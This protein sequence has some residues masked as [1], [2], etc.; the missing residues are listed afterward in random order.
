[1]LKLRCV[2]QNYAW[3]KLGTQ[4]LV[5]QIHKV[6]RPDDVEGMEEKPFAEFWMGDHTNGP[7]SVLID[8]N[9]ANVAS[10]IGD[11]EFV[12]AH[13]GQ[14]VTITKLFEL[15]NKKFLGEAYLNKLAAQDARLNTSL[16]YL[17]K[18]LSVRTA[19]SIQAH[20]NKALAEK[21]HAE[22]PDKYKDPNHKPEIAV[23]VSE[24][25]T[26]CYGFLGKDKLK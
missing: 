1:M 9:D 15:N 17:F 3:G 16:S 19:L 8:S 18:V 14:E 24:D 23:A 21:L 22:R 25:F 4:S 12:K 2:S 5:G 13:D 10:L 20:P 26:A 11:E 6:N 7:S